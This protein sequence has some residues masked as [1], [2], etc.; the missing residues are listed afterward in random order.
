MPNNS[1]GII[2]ILVILLVVGFIG[3][4]GFLAFQ[5]N[6][7]ENKVPEAQKTNLPQPQKTLLPSPS[8]DPKD[9][10]II[11]INDEFGFKLKHPLMALVE[12][13]GS[14]V[15]VWEKSDKGILEG[16]EA[17]P[18]TPFMSVTTKQLPSDTSLHEFIL[19]EEGIDDNGLS[20]YVSKSPV[21]FNNINGESYVFNGPYGEWYPIYIINNSNVFR[22]SSQKEYV[23]GSNDFFD[24]ILSTFEFVE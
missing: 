14:R 1:R 15:I 21:S 5:N 22:I 11:Y 12:E 8:S 20:E 16:T 7:L 3:A 4:V 23:Q 2:P 6:Q 13:D 24:Q 9:N 18:S 19:E 17:P 10:L